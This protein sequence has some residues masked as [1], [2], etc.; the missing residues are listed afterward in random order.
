LAGCN[1]ACA[2]CDTSYSWDWQSHDYATH[3]TVQYPSE[4]SERCGRAERLVI[5]GGEPLLQQR[6]LESVLSVLPASLPI[7]VETNGTV[8][9]A[10]ALLARVTQWNVS[11]KLSNSAE[12]SSRRLK[13]RVLKT[14]LG[15]GRAWLKLVVACPEDA[16][17]ALALVNE[18][19]WPRERVYLMPLAATR[20]HYR[21]TLPIVEDLSR[22]HGVHLSPRLHVERWNGVRGR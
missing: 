10:E 12:P 13:E 17:E 2:W 7:E 21:R 8:L 20:E 5:T 4:V 19:G 3:V 14:L 9:P 18:L 1:L 6:A 16:D 11:P 15:T 22:H